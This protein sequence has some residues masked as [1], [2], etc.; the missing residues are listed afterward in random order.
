MDKQKHNTEF[1]LEQQIIHQLLLCA[2]VGKDTGL[3]HG[4]MGLVLFFAHYFNFT[5]NSIYE[6]T[7][8]E[9]MEE[10]MNE[11]HVE[12]PMGFASGLSG[13]GWGLEYLIQN[14]LV[15]GDSLEVC[16]DIDKKIM[17]TDPR[18]I[19]D[20]SLETGLEGLLHY[21][22]AHIKGVSVQHSTLPFDAV[23]LRDLY[24]AVSTI[25]P[26]CEVSEEFKLV[27]AQYSHFYKN[28][29]AVDYS[30]SLSSIID[31]VEVK[32]GMLDRHPLGLKKGLAGFLL[33][34][35]ITE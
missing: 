21:V 11:I 29:T 3:Y 32:D 2:D 31:D 6:D 20:Y 1:T 5:K 18:R 17:E 22:L 13:I 15:E 19:T 4:K 25:S 35:I 23:Y 9:L 16:E 12:L 7:A 14:G 30:M 24:Q 8:E 10:L 34:K 33:K 28:K 26:D 27:A